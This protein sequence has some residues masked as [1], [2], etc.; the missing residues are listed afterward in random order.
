MLGQALRKK[1]FIETI[2]KSNGTNYRNQQNR[3]GLEKL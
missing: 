3:N 2:Q 1:L